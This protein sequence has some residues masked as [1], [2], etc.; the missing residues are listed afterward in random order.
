MKLKDLPVIETFGRNKITSRN[1][2]GHDLKKMIGCVA[3]S[4]IFSTLRGKLLYIDNGKC[5]FEILENKEWPKYNQCAGQIEYL[6]E[7]TAVTI[8]FEE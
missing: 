4:N 6:N 5:Y 2:Q 7:K 8:K 3:R 1:N